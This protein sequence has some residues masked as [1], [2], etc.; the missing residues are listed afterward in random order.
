[1]NVDI[2]KN[3]TST[4]VLTGVDV[5]KFTG[6]SQKYFRAYILPHIPKNTSC[7]ILEIGCGYGRYTMLLTSI[8]GYKNTVG[9]DISEEQIDYA[10]KNYNLKN[11]FKTD[12][13][14][15][16]KNNSA[17][18]KYDVVILMDVLEHLELNYAVE[19]LLH[20]NSVLDTG[21]KL[22][23]QVPNGLSP[24]KPIF[25][26]DVTHVRAFSVNSMSQ[27]LRMGG[28]NSFANYAIP[29]L[30]HNL[31]SLLHKI[32]WKVFIHPLIF[33]FVTLSHG[34]PAGGIYSSNLLT[35]AYKK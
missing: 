8:L 19:M 34:N 33:I 29:P 5:E 13:I 28:F 26:G 20:V 30:G 1:M 35:V 10:K 2:Y 4:S 24:M 22:I 6:W 25:Y 23:I 11:V 18:N 15:Y 7:R 27:I 17:S 16:L 14:E 21:G 31:K 3:Y 12:A 9:I 32:F